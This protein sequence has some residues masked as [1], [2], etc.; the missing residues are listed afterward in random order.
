M[1]N[2]STPVFSA[3]TGVKQD[4]FYYIYFKY[5]GPGT[6]ICQSVVPKRLLSFVNMY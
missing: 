5:C 3:M 6:P 1:Q 2:F 4:L